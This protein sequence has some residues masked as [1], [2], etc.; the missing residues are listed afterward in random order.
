VKSTLTKC[1]RFNNND[2]DNCDVN[3]NN[4]DNNTA[5]APT[6]NPQTYSGGG[7]KLMKMIKHFDQQDAA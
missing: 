5:K 1:S 7:T 2:I 3:N 4:Y 6:I